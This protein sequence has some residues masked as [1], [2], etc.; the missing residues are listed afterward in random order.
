MRKLLLKGIFLVFVIALIQQITAKLFPW[1]WGNR[2]LLTKMTLLEK[3]IKNKNFNTFFIGGSN[4]YRHVIPTVFD[5]LSEE[6]VISL[7]LGTDGCYPPEAYHILDNLITNYD[8][9][10]YV[11]VSLNSFDRLF[12]R[13][14]YRTTRTKYYINTNWFFKELLYLRD[15]KNQKW[16]KEM[17]K[18]YSVTFLENFFRIGYKKDYIKYFFGNWL[19]SEKVIGLDRDGYRA[20]DT[21]VTP[22]EKVAVNIPR[23]TKELQKHWE[24]AYDVDENHNKEYER[25]HLEIITDFIAKGNEKGIKIIFLLPPKSFLLST[26]PK[27]LALYNQIPESNRMSLANPANYPVFFQEQYRWDAGHLTHEGAK[28]YSQALAKE[29]NNL[30]K[31]EN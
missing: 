18:K 11:F 29:F 14:R 4:T 17:L 13:K 12:N 9:V 19:Y 16:R 30:V 22:N 15:I 23:R 1:N 6:N 27:M 24:R 21:P 2:A 8:G 28:L 10:E 25:I 3:E 5:S 20:F 7:N 26:I 31:N